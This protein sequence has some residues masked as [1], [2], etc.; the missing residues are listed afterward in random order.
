[1]KHH[2]PVT[3]ALPIQTVGFITMRFSVDLIRFTK[4]HPFTVGDKHGNKR[5]FSNLRCAVHSVAVGKGVYVQ[6]GEQEY[7]KA[8]CMDLHAR[9]ESEIVDVQSMQSMRVN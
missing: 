1:M 9:Y 7:N 4:K 2:E 5:Y 8:D 6:E 3:T